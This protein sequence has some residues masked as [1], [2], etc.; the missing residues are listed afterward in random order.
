[1]EPA[2]IELSPREMRTMVDNAKANIRF[3][4]EDGFISDSTQANAKIVAKL[5]NV[6][7]RPKLAIELTKALESAQKS[8]NLRINR[9]NNK[10]L[11][12]SKRLNFDG[13]DIEET[14]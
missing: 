13:V 12:A 3:E 2:K 4:L 14:W 7:G 10:P 5:C 8:S 6:T 1:V 11:P 9:K